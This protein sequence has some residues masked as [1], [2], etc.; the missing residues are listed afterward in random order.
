[1]MLDLLLLRSFVSVVEERSF[2]AAANRL[3]LTQPAISGH[4]RRLESQLGKAL[5]E[6]TTR[7]V[8]LT[9][10]GER[11]LGYA[12]AILALNRDAMEEI[13]RSGDQRSIR[14]GV[15][16][17]FANERLLTLLKRFMQC[18]AMV[19]IEVR[20]G[21]PGELLGAMR[22]GYVDMVLGAQCG[23]P[24][25]GI[26]LWREP[27]VWAWSEREEKELPSPLPLALF[28][29]PCPYREI[30]LAQLAMVGIAQRT[31]MLCMSGAGLHVAAATGFAVAPMPA[32][33][34]KPGLIALSSE[35][36]LPELP[37]AEIMLITEASH[38][39]Q[40]LLKALADALLA[41]MRPVRAVETA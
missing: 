15:S 1:M 19:D 7:S 29:E 27:L 35:H 40:D 38:S 34:L 36:G 30:A 11:L 13:S 31:A 37:A 23:E 28:P 39:D 9:P 26:R 22:Q 25:T 20:V 4:L 32:S 8:Q 17:D 24:V 14:L 3:H 18:H 21:I 12:R 2:T 41:G 6:R 16:E 33:Q 10:D 5:L